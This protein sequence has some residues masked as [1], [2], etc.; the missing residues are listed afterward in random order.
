M[1]EEGGKPGGHV[2]AEH[3]RGRGG[4][5]WAETSE[6]RT[7]LTHLKSGLVTVAGVEKGELD[8]EK[9]RQNG[10]KE[11]SNLVCGSGGGAAAVRTGVRSG[12]NERIEGVEC[13]QH[14]KLTTPA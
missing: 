12:A 10:L 3:T 11:S 13:R 4:G 6:K 8:L 9:D 7:P 1:F 14:P 2:C 5:V